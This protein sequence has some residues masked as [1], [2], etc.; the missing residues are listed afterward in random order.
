M[1][2]DNVK[3]KIVKQFEMA[4]EEFEFNFVSP[5]Y[6]GQNNKFCFLG[7]LFRD[8]PE[9]GVLI[10]VVFDKS[11]NIYYKSVVYSTVGTGWFLQFIVLNP[12]RHN[13]ELVDYLDKDVTP[14]KALVE[15]IQSDHSDFNI[16]EGSRM[17]KYKH[18]CKI[19]GIEVMDIKQMMGYSDVCENYA[20]LTDIFVNKSVPVGKYEIDIQHLKDTNE[21]NYILTQTDADDFMKNFASFHD[22]T[23]EK[24]SYSE[25]NESTSVKAVFD[26]SGLFG[27]VELCF[28][29]IKMLKIMPATEDYTREIYEAS[30]IIEDESVFWADCY[31]EKEDL[32]YEGS[33]IKALNLKWRKI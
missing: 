15:I 25:S 21:W 12:K 30:L 14:A 6:M 9:K 31:M 7:Y 13:F 11:E 3:K 5:H 26:N 4:S 33:I 8:N 29:G 1:L 23:L 2:D 24:I 17:L 20:F 27:I 22:G 10:D 32:S 19:N 18:F 16:Y 28:E